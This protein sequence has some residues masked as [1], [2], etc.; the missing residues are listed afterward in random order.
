MSGICKFIELPDEFK[1]L[2]KGFINGLVNYGKD[3]NN[4]LS[5]VKKIYNLYYLISVEDVDI[6]VD[7]VIISI[8][9]IVL[10]CLY[11]NISS[12]LISSYGLKFDDEFKKYYDI[13]EL[14]VSYDMRLCKLYADVYKCLDIVDIYNKYES[15][16]KKYSYNLCDYNSC[17]YDSNLTLQGTEYNNKEEEIQKYFNDNLLEL[18]NGI[19]NIEYKYKIYNLYK[20]LELEMDGPYKYILDL[21]SCFYDNNSD[22]SL[23]NALLKHSNTSFKLLPE[24]SPNIVAMILSLMSN[25][26]PN[27]VIVMIVVEYLRNNGIMINDIRDFG[28]YFKVLNFVEEILL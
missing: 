26:V 11:G 4:I 8:V 23:H 15:I 10:K 3:R 1:L 16:I 18:L 21:E 9:S 19:I 27:G 13:I 20:L 14:E 28:K 7:Y 25:I 2:L 17:P 12:R 6:K 22:Y 5:L 24:M